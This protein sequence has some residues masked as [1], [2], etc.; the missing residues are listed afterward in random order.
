MGMMQQKMPGQLGGGPGGKADNKP[1]LPSSRP[2]SANTGPGTP[3]VGSGMQCHTNM[4]LI[5]MRQFF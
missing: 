2:S 1:G 3:Q 4:I 5:Q